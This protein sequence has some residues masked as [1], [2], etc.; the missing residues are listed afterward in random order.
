MDTH[1]L[2]LLGT[3]IDILVYCSHNLDRSKWILHVK[4]ENEPRI[5]WSAYIVFS[6]NAMYIVETTVGLEW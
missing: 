3:Y 2:S 4:F 6:Q 5:S 1:L